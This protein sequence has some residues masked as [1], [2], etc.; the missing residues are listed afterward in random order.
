MSSY[1]YNN[2]HHESNSPSRGFPDAPCTLPLVGYDEL[3][4]GVTQHKV[5]H[6]LLTL[7]RYSL[8]QV[9]PRGIDL[10]VACRICLCRVIVLNTLSPRNIFAF[11]ESGLPLANHGT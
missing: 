8:C 9:G 1:Y 7:F 3:G 11:G 10:L 6:A 5:Q 4:R 2:C